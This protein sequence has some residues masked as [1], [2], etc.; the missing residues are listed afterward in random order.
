MAAHVRDKDHSN[1]QN[2][3]LCS[4]ISTF[5]CCNKHSKV[6]TFEGLFESSTFVY[7][8]REA[9]RRASEPDAQCLQ[10]LAA[11]Q[12]RD[13]SRRASE[14]EAEHSQ[15]LA[16][17]QHRVASLRASESEAEHSQRLAANQQ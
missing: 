4:E 15:R 3:P 6:G 8:L 12:Q 17:N 13:A 2:T 11:N 5:E 14:S 9:N 7:A 10:R 16:A 1:Y